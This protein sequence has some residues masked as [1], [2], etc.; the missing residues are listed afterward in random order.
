MNNETTFDAVICKDALRADQRRLLRR[1][2]PRLT[3]GKLNIVTPPGSGKTL[4]GLEIVRRIGA[5][6][7]IF[8]ADL[9]S[10]RHWGN[11]FLRCFAPEGAGEEYLSYDLRTPSA[12]TCLSYNALHAALHHTLHT[13]DS[14]SIDFSELDIIHLIHER[15]IRTVL[16]DEPYHLRHHQQ[17]ALETLLGILGGEIHVLTLTANPPYDLSREEWDRYVSLCGEPHSEVHMAEL[18]QAGVNCPHEDLLY[19]SYPTRAES[20]LLLEHRR[21]AEVAIAEIAAL[22]FMEQMKHRLTHLYSRERDYILSHREAVIALSELLNEYQVELNTKLYRQLTGRALIA[23]LTVFSA[24][25]AVQFLLNSKVM[26][27]NSEKERLLSL[28]REHDLLEHNRVSLSMPDSLRGMVS[29]SVSKADSVA[30][31]TEA[32]AERMGDSLRQ[33]V[34]T[35]SH[36]AERA[37]FEA[38][39]ETPAHLNAPAILR[40]IHSRCPRIPLGYVSRS[41]TLLPNGAIENPAVTAQPS[42]I[43]GYSYFRFPEDESPFRAAEKLL[44]DGTVRVL[45]GPSEVT[46]KE[47][48]NRVFNTLVIAA[49]DLSYTEITRARGRVIHADR[50]L[51]DKTAHIWHLATVELKY[52]ALKDASLRL[53][54]R[55]ATAEPHV[56]AAD[57]VALRRR[58]ACF[59][60]P[61]LGGK[62]LE[63]GAERLAV[64]INDTSPEGLRK[65]NAAMLERVNSREELT[66]TWT[67]AISE[68]VSPVPEVQVPQTAR[69][70]IPPASTLLVILTL[71]T[72]VASALFTV[73]TL[74]SWIWI[75]IKLAPII[76]IP[77]VIIAG[78]NTI[79]MCISVLY[80]QHMAPLLLHH[81]STKQSIHGM[82]Y[83]LLRTLKKLKLVAATATLVMEARPSQKTFRIYL[84]D[85]TYAQQLIYQRALSE[86]L[87]P[88]EEPRYIMVRGGWF[89]RLL[90][91]WSLACPSVIAANDI[92]VKVFEHYVRPIMGPM[93][94][95]FTRREP[96]TQYLVKAR[97][98]TFINA[99]PDPHVPPIACVTRNCLGQGHRR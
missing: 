72:A 7:L 33:F 70:P 83:A 16:L 50:L 57:L 79:L 64:D 78:V 8:S 55:M 75:S 88:I 36:H 42:G 77:T 74:I 34:L 95:Q 23:R 61:V 45:L 20:E 37:D 71:I 89:N 56:V 81:H 27:K 92:S 24:E 66:R 76:L 49:G 68:G 54:S 44:R 40:A 25:L 67:E 26:L 30:A 52:A 39:E 63:N 5:P 85:C 96:G 13:E 90:W 65:V 38:E 10:R 94:F 47:R 1:V 29:A 12:V 84:K 21:R 60:G 18:I 93:K 87:S 9:S 69:I 73:P 41:V 19:L 17:R 3:A 14:L 80:L 43:E 22:P 6:C 4:L 15:G 48:D 11:T 97:N 28:L 2:Q 51:P 58:F 82:A 86:L 31:I 59:I 53:T 46:E 91:R 98:R 99:T 32:E 35:S 62:G